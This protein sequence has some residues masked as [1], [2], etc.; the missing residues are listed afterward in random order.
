VQGVN[1]GRISETTERPSLQ[2]TIDSSLV[3]SRFQE[4]SGQHRTDSYFA[5]SSAVHT[6]D[7]RRLGPNHGPS[8]DEHGVWQQGDQNGGERHDL[9]DDWVDVSNE[10]PEEWATDDPYGASSPERRSSL[11]IR[12]RQRL[13]E[14]PTPSERR[15]TFP[16]RPNTDIGSGSG[17]TERPPPHLRLQLQQPFVRPRSGLDHDNLGDVYSKIQE[18][19]SKLKLINSDIMA[20]QEDCYNEIADGTRIKGWLLVGRGLRYVPGI[21]I[22][23]GRAK[24]DIRWDV[25]QHE[26][27]GL[28]TAV[29]WMIVVIVVLLLAAGCGYPAFIFFFFSLQVI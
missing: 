10:P 12:L 16:R 2:E 25:L 14:T 11:G 27:T 4:G 7:P 21:Q 23:E 5:P 17:S 18:W 28:D 22:I 9:G 20:V 6:P 13:I 15:E 26:R 1:G 3:G 8:A 29:L 24:E 19:R